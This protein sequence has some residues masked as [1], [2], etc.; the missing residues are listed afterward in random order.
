MTRKGYLEIIIRFETWAVTK[1]LR[2]STARIKIVR[3]GWPY[4]PYFGT[5]GG[6]AVAFGC[7]ILDTIVLILAE[8]C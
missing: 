6:K 5:R 2:K 4:K 1:F 8:L 7:L 3:I